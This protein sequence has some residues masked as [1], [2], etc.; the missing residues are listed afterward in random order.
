L[1]L[2]VAFLRRIYASLEHDEERDAVDALEAHALHLLPA[3]RA[4]E[5]LARAEYATNGWFWAHWSYCPCFNGCPRRDT[6][7]EED[8]AVGAELLDCARTR[9]YDPKGLASGAAEK[10][11]RLAANQDEEA[12]AQRHL[13][14]DI[15][16]PPL[17]KPEGMGD[18]R[19]SS[20]VRDL[21]LVLNRQRLPD[22]LGMLALSDA[23]EEAGCTNEEML[24][25]C[26]SDGVH[27]RGCWVI[28]ELI[29]RAAR[30]LPTGDIPQ[31]ASKRPAPLVPMKR[32]TM[33]PP[34]RARPEA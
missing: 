1:F 20:A 30:R 21:V 19:G 2:A 14:N 5:A 11:R 3:E 33:K 13:Y 8:L 12:R 7:E 15:I 23:L 27:H 9:L 6:D 17:W 16:G 31:P 29:G 34:N 18:V 22:P 10:V 25:H 4:V 32:N 26:R 24:N 28:E